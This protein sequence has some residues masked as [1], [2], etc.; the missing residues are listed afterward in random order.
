MIMKKLIALF[1]LLAAV[2]VE[3]QSASVTLAWNASTGWPATNGVLSYRV[4]ASTNG[5]RMFVSPLTTNLTCTL[6]GLSNNITY[7]F[8]ATAVATNGLESEQS[9]VV[10]YTSA[11]PTAPT[12]LRGSVIVTTVTTVTNIIQFT[13]P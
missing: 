10:Y 11:V 4:Y 8:S 1:V 2:A 7:G 9:G 12:G 3:A 5:S 13:S 6:Y